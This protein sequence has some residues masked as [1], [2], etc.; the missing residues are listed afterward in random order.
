M[1][2]RRI[3]SVTKLMIQNNITLGE[4][5][6]ADYRRFLLQSA[7]IRVGLYYIALGHDSIALTNEV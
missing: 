4:G 3:L 6:F 7:V 1:Q 2:S 5:Y